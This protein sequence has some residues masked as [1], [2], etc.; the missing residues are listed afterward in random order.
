MKL[1]CLVLLALLLTFELH[2]QSSSFLPIIL[3]PKKENL[4]NLSLGLGFA[5]AIRYSNDD[6]NR[7]HDLR[8]LANLSVNLKI[9]HPFYVSMG[10]EYHKKDLD[11]Y[12]NAYN[13][14][15]LFSLGGTAFKRKITYFAEAGPNLLAVHYAREQSI[16]FSWGL[17]I[18]FRAQYNLTEKYAVGINAR[19]INYFNI[20]SEHYFIIHSNIYFAVKI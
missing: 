13:L 5:V 16:G 6:H 15:G 19:H 7:N 10:F 1:A 12:D 17:S 11:G 9:N 4:S 2:A 14:F 3:K 8:F 20:W 18:G